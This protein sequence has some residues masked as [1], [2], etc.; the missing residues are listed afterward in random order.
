M[1][2]DSILRAQTAARV[3]GV[4]AQL[5]ATQAYIRAVAAD[6][7]SGPLADEL[8]CID[9]L[10]ANAIEDVEEIAEALALPPV[11]PDND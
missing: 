7:A 2:S 3:A 6:P 4:H 9:R 10:V 5:M 8:I 11:V 1:T